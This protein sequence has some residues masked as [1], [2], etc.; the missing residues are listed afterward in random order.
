MYPTRT[1]D[2]AS[3]VGKRFLKLKTSDHVSEVPKQTVT[4]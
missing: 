3:E 2:V 1:F 4:I